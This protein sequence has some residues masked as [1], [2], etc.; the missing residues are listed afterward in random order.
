MMGTWIPVQIDTPNLG[1]TD[2]QPLTQTHSHQIRNFIGI[3]LLFFH[4]AWLPHKAPTSLY[5]IQQ[6]VENTF[7]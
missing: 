7:L 5:G 1:F 6:M 3:S 2:N 4:L